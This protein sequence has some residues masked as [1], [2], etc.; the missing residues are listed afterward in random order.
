M[1][2]NERLGLRQTTA[3]RASSRPPLCLSSR[4]RFPRPHAN[5]RSPCRRS[6]I[7]VVMPNSFAAGHPL[8]GGN[9]TTGLSHHSLFHSFALC[10]SAAEPRMLQPSG[11]SRIVACCTSVHR[12][13]TFGRRATAPTWLNSRTFFEVGCAHGSHL[14]MAPQWRRKGKN[15]DLVWPADRQST[16]GHLTSET[17][18]SVNQRSSRQISLQWVDRKST[19][20]NSSHGYISYA[21]F[22]LKKNNDSSARVT[23]ADLP[24]VDSREALRRLFDPIDGRV[25]KYAAMAIRGSRLAA[26]FPGALAAPHLK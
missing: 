21:V 16:H 4:K 25:S 22:C 11:H 23:V 3:Y 17:A 20:L 10:A 2:R 19:R 1:E 18:G 13:E 5:S 12:H 26:S 14:Q 8:S 15:F 9:K 7:L 24:C 6:L